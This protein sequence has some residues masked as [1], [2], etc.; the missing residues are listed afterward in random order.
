MRVTGL[1][2]SLVNS[3]LAYYCGDGIY[4]C[5]NWRTD[6]GEVKKLK[7]IARLDWIKK[8]LAEELAIGTDLLVLEGR[9]PAGISDALSLG[10]LFAVLELTAFERN[11]P[12]LVVPP[13]SRIAYMS[14][15]KMSTRDGT[16]VLKRSAVNLARSEFGF[17]QD[18]D[19]NEADALYLARIG[20]HYLGLIVDVDPKRQEV[21]ANLRLTPEERKRAEQDRKIAEAARIVASRSKACQEVS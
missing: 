10:G 16:E 20:A 15:G 6:I 7:G 9:S 3:G 18:I 11:V 4:G 12:V 8:Q 5:D 13:A 17:D 21:I 19:D 2:Q 14:R 1:D